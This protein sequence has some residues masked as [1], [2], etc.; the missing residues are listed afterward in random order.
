MNFYDLDSKDMDR[1]FLDRTPVRCKAVVEISLLTALSP[2]DTIVVRL[3]NR[4]KYKGRIIRFDYEMNGKFADG[5]LE[6]VRA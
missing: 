3:T 5:F 1:A 6:I 2:G 4:S